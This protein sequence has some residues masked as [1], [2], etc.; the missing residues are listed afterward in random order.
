MTSTKEN[1]E[2][3]SAPHTEGHGSA[4]P[5]RVIYENMSIEELIEIRDMISEIIEKKAGKLII[6][7]EYNQ[8]KGTGKAWAAEID[9]NGKIIKFLD[10]IASE[11]NRYKG[12]KKYELREGKKYRLND[13]G[14][15]SHDY[16]RDVIVINGKL[17]EIE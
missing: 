10:A 6:Q 3:E 9:E 12:W 1:K 5:A 15:K 2:I 17:E 8:Y 13:E 7:L 16:R 4:Q 11:R 14:S